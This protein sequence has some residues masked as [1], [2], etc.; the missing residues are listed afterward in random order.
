MRPL[1][2]VALGGPEQMVQGGGGAGLQHVLLHAGYMI[3]NEN[4]TE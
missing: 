4:I 3:V 1:Q 2:L